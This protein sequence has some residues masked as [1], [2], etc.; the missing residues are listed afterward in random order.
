[1]AEDGVARVV[2]ILGAV[3]STVLGAPVMAF[4]KLPEGL[5]AQQFSRGQLGQAPLQRTS[6]HAYLAVVSRGSN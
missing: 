2:A 3:L 4:A 1:M 6:Q 5:G